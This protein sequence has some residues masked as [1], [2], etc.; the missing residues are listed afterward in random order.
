MQVERRERLF[1]GSR[2]CLGRIG[3]WWVSMT[4]NPRGFVVGQ[5]VIVWKVW[6]RKREQP[7]ASQCLFRAHTAQYSLLV[8][9]GPHRTW[10]THSLELLGNWGTWWVTFELNRNIEWRKLTHSGRGRLLS[11]PPSIP[12]TW[13][14][15]D[16]SC[17]PSS[18]PSEMSPVE[19][20][21]CLLLT[22]TKEGSLDSLMTNTF[23]L[24]LGLG[25]ISVPEGYKRPHGFQL[26]LSSPLHILQKGL[27][28]LVFF[29][30]AN[31]LFCVFNLSL[32]FVCLFV[33]S[34]IGGG[35]K[36][37]PSLPNF[38]PSLFWPNPR[39]KKP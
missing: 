2:A 24:D 23:C 7:A 6:E 19:W 12:L 33:F 31:D 32:L 11:A 14:L 39:G 8:L 1:P 34:I 28:I 22:Y 36:L 21:F 37:F 13:N 30:L 5:W 29:C 16:S 17:L 3:T 26:A 35:A 20:P 9:K 27:Q 15:R 38:D 4:L 10:Q 18:E 25:S